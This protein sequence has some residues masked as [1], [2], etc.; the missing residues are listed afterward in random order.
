MSGSLL[1]SSDGGSD[2]V[3]T[4]GGGGRDGDTG[5][6][7]NE[8]DDDGAAGDKGSVDGGAERS[9]ALTHPPPGCS[10]VCSIS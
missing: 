8:D 10:T 1:Y 4:V 9:I 2:D 7:V 6:G 3:E 5:G